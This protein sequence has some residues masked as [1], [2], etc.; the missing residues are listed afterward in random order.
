MKVVERNVQEIGK[1]LLITL[2]K[3]WTNLIKLKKGSKLKLIIGEQGNLSIA[4]EFIKSTESHQAVIHFDDYFRRQFFREY[5]QGNEKITVILKKKLKDK[6][7]KDLY[8]F[9]KRF[10]NVQV[11]E[12]TDSRIVI[13]AFKIDD[14]SVEECLKRMHFLSLNMIDEVISG[15]SKTK[16]REMRDTSTRFYYM[17][18]MQVRRFLSEGKFIKENQI[19]LIRALDI[20]MV[21]EKI[22]RIVAI[23]HSL[24]D[25]KD[26]G[27]VKQLR[28]IKAY[29]TDAF[30]CFINDKYDKALMLWQKGNQEQ[31]VFDRMME[32]FVKRK[33]ARLYQNASELASVLRYAKE[34]SMLVR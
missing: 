14:L 34:I 30:G 13:K 3:E 16:L 20:R 25:L 31:K 19:S 1:S 4:P 33:N 7:K 17:L 9:L 24:D 21:A 22:Q 15:N 29:Y 26:N 6:E 10:I 32:S 27:L 28:E 8:T 18:V 11:I 23:M 5:F 12:E 2:P